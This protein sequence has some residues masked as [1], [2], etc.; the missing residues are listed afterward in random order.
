MGCVG[1]TGSGGVRGGYS[2]TFMR[3]GDSR[4]RLDTR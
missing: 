1:G 3:F 4:S 2:Q